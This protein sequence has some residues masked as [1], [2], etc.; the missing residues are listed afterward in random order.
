MRRAALL[1]AAAFLGAWTVPPQSERTAMW[2]VGHPSALKAVLMACRNDPGHAK[3]NPDCEN[4]T[5]AEIILSADQASANVDLT[6][7]SNPRYWRIHPEQLGPEMF[8]CEH[9]Q[10]AETRRAIFCDSAEAAERMR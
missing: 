1:Y 6:P 10:S 8:H 9:A 5:Q 4:A 2:Y 7:P 3:T